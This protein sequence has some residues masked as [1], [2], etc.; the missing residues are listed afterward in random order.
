MPQ[1]IRNCRPIEDRFTV[2]KVMA[3]ERERKKKNG[4][5]IWTVEVSDGVH[6]S[7]PNCL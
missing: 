7:A 1:G 6:L 2:A 4:G 3:V 5:K